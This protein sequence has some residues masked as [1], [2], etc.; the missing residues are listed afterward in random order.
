MVLRHLLIA[1]QLKQEGF[2]QEA[3]TVLKHL[4]SKQLFGLTGREEY[5]AAHILVH[6][7][8]VDPQSAMKL[9]QILLGEEHR[10]HLVYYLSGSRHFKM[11][12]EIA[13]YFEDPEETRHLFNIIAG[14]Q[15]MCSDFEGASETYRELATST[16]FGLW[17][18]S[19]KYSDEQA[20][21]DAIQQYVNSMIESQRPSRNEAT[22]ARLDELVN[23]AR[24]TLCEA[25][26]ASYR[27]SEQAST[28][29]KELA[30]AQARIGE[31]GRAIALALELKQYDSMQG[32]I[33]IGEVALE[34][35]ATGDLKTSRV[36]IEEAL[37]L[38]RGLD[39]KWGAA[40]TVGSLALL[41]EA[42]RYFDDIVGGAMLESREMIAQLIFESA[43]EGD[44]DL[45]AKVAA[46]L[47]C[48]L[49]KAKADSDRSFI[50]ELMRIWDLAQDIRETDRRASACIE[51]VG[52][53]AEVGGVDDA[54][55]LVESIT[56]EEQQTAAYTKIAVALARD[57]NIHQARLLA[58]NISQE[59]LRECVLAEIAVSEAH[60]ANFTEARR[61]ADGLQRPALIVKAFSEISADYKIR[62]DNQTA[63]SILNEVI[64][65]CETR[66]IDVVP[67]RAASYVL[68]QFGL[69]YIRR[70]QAG[71]GV[72]LLYR[73]DRERDSA[74]QSFEHF[75]AMFGVSNFIRLG[76]SENEMLQ[77]VQTL[78][79]RAMA[80]VDDRHRAAAAPLR[81]PIQVDS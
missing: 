46:L 47:V 43:E 33:A 9:Q 12:R 64:T 17:N 40:A 1:W 8:D 69:A 32:A 37:V 23:D 66:G 22:R 60:N 74:E 59:P 36:L 67:G 51:V 18:F 30:V 61:I 53:L 63:G 41:L 49:K 20:R 10:A 39:E 72:A 65:T 54:L 77:R 79:E 28:T 14:R 11:A 35:A 19:F 68:E 13:H 81:P 21:E 3:K 6:I 27:K 44:A 24:R 52:A 73:A 42:Y 2:S 62:G 5:I 45:Q 71:A 25:E 56:P 16:M 31:H 50:P 38:A 75:N 34:V 57:G 4:F 7:V 26:P 15:V 55:E 58:Q 29:F 70:G 80:W 48:V 76:K 78:G